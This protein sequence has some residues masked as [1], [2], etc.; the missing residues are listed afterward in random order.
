M[1]EE[2]TKLAQLLALQLAVNENQEKRLLELERQARR[3][4]RPKKEG[5]H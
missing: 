1:E 5:L 4:R 3:K 2:I